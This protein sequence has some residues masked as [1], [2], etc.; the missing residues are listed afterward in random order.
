[1]RDTDVIP[2]AGSIE[3][4]DSGTME[5]LASAIFSSLTGWTVLEWE[6]IGENSCVQKVTRAVFCNSHGVQTQDIFREPLVGHD[7]VTCEKVREHV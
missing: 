3:I 2:D 5:L 7:C 1:M 6:R 4:R